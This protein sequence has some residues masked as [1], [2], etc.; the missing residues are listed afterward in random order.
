MFHD[1]YQRQIYVEK[2][3]LQTRDSTT[4][5]IT[6]PSTNADD[7]DYNDDGGVDDDEVGGGGG[8]GGGDDHHHNHHHHNHRQNH[9]DDGGSCNAMMTFNE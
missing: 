3:N 5:W 9:Y 8:G 4:S 7:A 6:I 2:P 1:K